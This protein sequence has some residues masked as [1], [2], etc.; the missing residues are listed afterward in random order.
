[1]TVVTDEKTGEGRLKIIDFEKLPR[2]LQE[3]LRHSGNDTPTK[4]RH[5]LEKPVQDL[6]TKRDRQ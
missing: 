6:Q 2:T 1:M 5:R 4:R 3:R